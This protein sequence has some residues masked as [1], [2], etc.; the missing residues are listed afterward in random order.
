MGFV[1]VWS[2]ECALAYWCR[3]RRFDYWDRNKNR[4]N[5]RA[6]ICNIF[7]YFSFKVNPSKV[8]SL[9]GINK[10]INEILDKFILQIVF[11][12]SK[13]SIFLMQKLKVFP[14]CKPNCFDTKFNCIDLGQTY[15][16]TQLM[17][18]KKYSCHSKHAILTLQRFVRNSI[19]KLHRV[20][21][22][23]ES[24]ETSK[25]SQLEINNH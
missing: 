21:I 9:S 2:S 13:R 20:E 1:R 23:Y 8:A 14:S 7:L 6:I 25:L 11:I 4:K 5:S 12:H 18:P 10:K 17:E 15:W 19:K 3:V 16:P 22:S 24:K